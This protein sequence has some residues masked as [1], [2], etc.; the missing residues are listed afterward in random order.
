MSA[1][2][3]PAAAK[4]QKI[5]LLVVDDH[6]VVR[7][8]LTSALNLDGDGTFGDIADPGEAL[9]GADLAITLTGPILSVEGRIATMDILGVVTLEGG[10]ALKTSKVDVDVNGNGTY[11]GEPKSEVDA[12]LNSSDMKK[13]F[14]ELKKLATLILSNSNPAATVP[15]YTA[16]VPPRCDTKVETNWGEP[17]VPG[18]PCFDYFP[19]IYH[20][21]NLKLQGGRGQ[22]ILLVEGDLVAS[23]GMKPPER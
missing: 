15:A 23:G 21:G 14:D 12:S 22:G 10:F 7:L 16:T 6:F 2:K 17:T 1:T 5:R 19:I 8:G 11:D 13:D 20:N 9:D 3:A 4:S 18:D